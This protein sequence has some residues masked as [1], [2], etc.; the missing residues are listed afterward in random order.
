MGWVY[1]IANTERQLVKVGRTD[2]DPRHRL[3]Q[4]QTG[5]PDQLEL[6]WARP[7][8]DPA[9][10]E[11]CMHQ[12]LATHHHRGEWYA[13]SLDQVVEAWARVTT[14]RI[15]W[16][17]GLRWRAI[18]ARRRSSAW[19]GRLARITGYATWAVLAIFCAI[20]LAR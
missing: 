20:Q 10:A 3:R 4:L 17:Y 8:P 11:R 14:G 18:R 19:L 12:L 9:T 1:C 6:L 16:W 5:Q 2:G 7:T 13:V 15:G